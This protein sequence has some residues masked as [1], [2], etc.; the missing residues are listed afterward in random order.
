MAKTHI[1]SFKNSQIP[2][3]L[4]HWYLFLSYFDSSNK[5]NRFIFATSELSCKLLIS[6]SSSFPLVC[7]FGYGMSATRF[8]KNSYEISKNSSNFQKLISNFQKLISNFQKLISNEQKT[9]IKTPKTPKYRQFSEVE[10]GG[11]C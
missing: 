8:D 10:F 1:K 2:A 3:F 5:G 9:H 7:I 11:F 4:L 6:F